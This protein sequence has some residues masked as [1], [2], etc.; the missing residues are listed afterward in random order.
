MRRVVVNVTGSKVVV[1]NAVHRESVIHLKRVRRR[2]VLAL[3]HIHSR[4]PR[5]PG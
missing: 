2:R 5:T 4:L 1:T 3:S